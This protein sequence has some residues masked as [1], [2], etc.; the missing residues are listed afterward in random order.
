[1]RD[2]GAMFSAQMVLELWEGRKTQTRRLASSPLARAVPGDRIWV[3]ETFATAPPHGYRY[4]ATDAVHDLRKKRPAIHMPRVA[5]RLT[6]LVTEVRFQ[7]LHDISEEDAQ[8]EGI[9]EPYLGDADP[10]WEEQAIIVSRKKQY[11]NLWKRLHGAESWD[12]NPDVVAISFI[13]VKANIDAT[14]TCDLCAGVCRRHSLG[15]P[16]QWKAEPWS[17]QWM[18]EKAAAEGGQDGRDGN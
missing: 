14:R 1:M 18:A 13:V 16:E 17:L 4:F 10:P 15:H 6:L 11:R 5:S 2:L 7:K 3:R 8:A 9:G 12:S